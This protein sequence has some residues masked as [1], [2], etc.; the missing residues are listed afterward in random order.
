M[1]PR[2][3]GPKITLQ[4]VKEGSK[5]RV[6][7]F[8][9]TDDEG[10]VYKNAYD[11]SLNCQ[12][13]RDIRR[14]GYFYEIS[15]EDLSLSTTRGKSFYVVRARGIKVVPNIDLSSMKIF[16]IQECVICMTNDT[17]GILCPCGH[18]CVCVE[19]SALFEKNVAKCPICRAVIATIL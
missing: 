6:R 12:F 2:N 5:L 3:D 8:S 18:K 1:Q 17:S 14:E 19:C 16:E 11:D 10:T 4:C 7:F 15:P 9:Y 13:P